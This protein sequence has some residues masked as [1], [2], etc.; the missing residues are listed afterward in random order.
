MKNYHSKTT[1][2]STKP[3]FSMKW[4]K[5]Q[6]QFLFQPWVSRN[7]AI[8]RISEKARSGSV[9]LLRHVWWTG[10][11]GTEGIR[12]PAAGVSRERHA[13]GAREQNWIC[14]RYHQ[15]NINT[16]SSIVKTGYNDI[17]ETAIFDRLTRLDVITS[18]IGLRIR[19]CWDSF[20]GCYIW[21]LV[22]TRVATNSFV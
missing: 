11:V 2:I 6:K 12:R 14:H 4:I 5:H 17:D 20:L 1:Y 16:I 19:F 7:L 13:E 18:V 22:K 15:Q 8:L 9:I 3:Q 21:Y 10:F